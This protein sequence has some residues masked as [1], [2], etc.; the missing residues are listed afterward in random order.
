MFGV[1]I[2]VGA[3][4]EQLSWT[5]ASLA[6]QAPRPLVALMDASADPRVSAL[7]DRF[8][9]L[10]TVRRHAPDDGQADAIASGWDALPEARV[11]AWLNADDWLY[12]GALAAASR[13]FANAGA[14]VVYAQSLT[15]SP[16]GDALG[17]HSAVAA[18]SS[19]ILHHNTISQPS[20]FATREAV[21]ASGGLDRTLD[22]TMDWDLWIKLHLSGARFAMIDE[23]WSAVTISTD[24]KT[25]SMNAKRMREIA[26][27]VRA[28]SGAWRTAKTLV[29]FNLNHVASYVLP[30]VGRALDQGPVARI[31]GV[32][33]ELPLTQYAETPARGLAAT[34]AGLSDENAVRLIDEA[35]GGAPVT[36]DRCG[37]TITFT[38]EAGG[39]P[40]APYRLACS[41]AAP[42]RLVRAAWLP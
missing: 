28:T 13:A 2:P 24:T 12:P 20:C 15:Q 14:D 19:V 25:G 5:F 41:A 8:E 22:Y 10:F 33:W 3:W 7:A 1:A 40:G 38:F 30:S 26:R 29:G 11:L 6:A 23:V 32:S 9:G 4:T 18:P 39:K 16:N 37:Q 36:G 34:F 35:A 17:L 21:E 31:E 27:L 42:V